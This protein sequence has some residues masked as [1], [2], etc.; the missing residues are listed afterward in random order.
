MVFGMEARRKGLLVNPAVEIADGEFLAR[1]KPLYSKGYYRN[2][3]RML[4]LGS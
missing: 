3:E 1:L 4:R 2:V